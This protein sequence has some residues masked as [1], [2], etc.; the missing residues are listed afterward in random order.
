MG[1]AYLGRHVVEQAL[2][3]GDEVTLF[4]RGRSA[5]GLFGERV[6]ELHGDRGGDLAALR[7]GVWDA[8]IDV[9]GYVPEEVDASSRLL[10]ERVEHLTFVSTI[11][12]YE[13]L[14][15]RG[16]RRDRARR[17][18]ARRATGR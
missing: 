4:N 18:A 14:A 12:A 13:S 9:S 2:A 17:A 6:R 1:R 5:P 15:A 10:A 8:A 11:R 7:G 3:R 16:H